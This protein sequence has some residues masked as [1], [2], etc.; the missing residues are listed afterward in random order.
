MR[1]EE[2]Q[3]TKEG[4]IFPKKLSFFNHSNRCS[5]ICSLTE[6]MLKGGCT[7]FEVKP[8]FLEK[9]ICSNSSPV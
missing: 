9:V 5:I 6:S 2:L 1:N 4:D 8:A 7:R 3:I